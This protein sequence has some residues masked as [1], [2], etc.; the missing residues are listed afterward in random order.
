MTS[1]CTVNASMLYLSINSGK[2]KQH[3]VT[4]RCV[5]TGKANMEIC[6]D[7]KS[8]TFSDFSRVQLF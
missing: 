6:A 2:K 8:V 1:V 5:H 3:L 4:E 7:T